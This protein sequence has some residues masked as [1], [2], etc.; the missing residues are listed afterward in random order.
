[1]VTGILFVLRS[2][3]PWNMQPRRGGLLRRDNAV[4]APRPVAE[5]RRLEARARDE[6]QVPDLTTSLMVARTP[7]QN[8][9]E[10]ARLVSSGMLSSVIDRTTPELPDS[11][12]KV[13]FR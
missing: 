6:S 7:D 12:R 8:S 3:I 10:R 4:A 2:G 1:M 5:G 13:Q 9:S 11:M